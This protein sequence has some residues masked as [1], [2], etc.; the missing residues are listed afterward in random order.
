MTK[1]IKLTI[2]LV[3][4]TAFYKNV[5]SEVSSA[6]WDIIRRTAYKN[7]GYVCEICGGKGDKHPVECHE[8]WEY[9]KGVQRLVR[10]IALC[11]KCHQVKHFGL[12]Q[13]RGLEEECIK[14]LMKVNGWGK[15]TALEYIDSCW[16]I[17]EARSSKSW[18]L[19]IS[20][21]E[22]VGGG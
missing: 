3:P 1:E 15:D 11:P 4:E 20:V 17:W 22:R 18:T 5:R 8:V 19:D 13:M 9:K 10:F 14:H 6:E 7:A 2:E 12:S 16:E 21:I